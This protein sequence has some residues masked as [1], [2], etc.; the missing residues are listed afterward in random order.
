MNVESNIELENY[1][2]TRGK[3]ILNACPGGGKTTAI[4]LKIALLETEIADTRGKFSGIACLSF[5][6][7]AKDEIND[8]YREVNEK[9]LNFPNLV[10]TIDSFINRY[11]TLP[12]YYLMGRN[13]KRPKILEDNKRVNKLFVRYYKDAKGITQEALKD[14]IKEF[15]TLNGQILY[16]KYKPE[17]IRLEPDGSYTWNGKIP[18]LNV[19]NPEVFTNYC[20]YIKRVQFEEGLITT[21]DSAY[22]A[23]YI[24]VKYPKIAKWLTSR[25]PCII[26]DEAQDNSLLQH[27]IFECL[28]QAG[29]NHIEFIGDPYQSLYEWRDA[30]PQLFINK[31]EDTTYTNLPFTGNRRSPKHIINCFSLMRPIKE[32]TIKYIGNEKKIEPILVYRFGNND[33]TEI[34]KHFERKCKDSKYLKRKIVVRGNEKLNELIG[35]N[36]IQEPWHEREAYAI[37]RI[38]IEFEDRNLKEAINL[39][40]R[41]VIDVVN[42]K[43]TYS[44][45]A[46]LRSEISTDYKFN[47]G[48]ID[49]IEGLPSLNLT[50][51]EW[52]EKTEKYLEDVLELDYSFDLKL[53]KRASS[54]VSKE[55]FDDPVSKHFKRVNVDEISTITTVHQVKGKTLDAILVL[56][57]EKNHG[58]NIN[59][60][61]L[62]PDR[63]GFLKEKKRIIYVA[64]SR[65]KHLLALAFP[66]TVSGEE[67][68]KKLGSNVVI[69]NPTD[70]EQL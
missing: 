15:K 25:F 11:I 54:K 14:D 33:R 28:T 21:N 64:M 29:L 2:K 51:K 4:A 56:F 47:A 70:L 41:I 43:M 69:I 42:P 34:V 39:A 8:K 35:R 7:A 12:Y 62:E 63:K 37:I 22:C 27:K 18:D 65:P 40:R 26:I 13:Y 20:K 68:I 45:R 50:V 6:N 49:F 16:H 38:C 66:S 48:L 31:C 30:D 1:L 32:R 19:V 46:N 23:Y 44:D 55:T 61:D 5:T 59:F 58:S 52:T 9:S 24:L 36:A 67:I 10:S 57:D 60:K 17:K 53:K 3:V